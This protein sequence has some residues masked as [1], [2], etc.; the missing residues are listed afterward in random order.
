MFFNGTLYYGGEN[1]D[2]KAFSVSNATVSSVLFKS[3]TTFPF[4]GTIPSLSAN[5]TSNAILWT[6]NYNGGT[7]SIL[8]AYDPTKLGAVIWDSTMASGSRDALGNGIKFT[9]P[10]VADGHVFVGTASALV[11]YGLSSV[12]PLITSGAPPNGAAGTAYNF[13]YT[14]TG[15]PYPT[16][17]ATPGTLPPGLTLS[18]TGTLS[19]TP[20]SGGLFTGTV[21]ASNGVNPAVIQ[22]FTI[23]IT[24]TYGIWV[25][26]QG[27]TGNQALPTAI[28]SSRRRHQPDEIRARAQSVHRLQ[29]GQP[30]PAAGAGRKIRR[31]AVS[32]PHFHRRR[33]RCNLYRTGQQRSR[34]LDDHSVLQWRATAGHRDGAGQPGGVRL[35]DALHAPADLAVDA[36]HWTEKRTLL[37]SFVSGSRWKPCASITIYL[38]IKEGHPNGIRTRAT[39]VKGR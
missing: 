17:S 6:I 29:P 34:E 7:S 14:A 3:S 27:L 12:A 23:T 25:T 10:T 15:A 9:V 38:L 33:D 28:V 13:N 30:Q 37:H 18:T 19:G 8:R 26:Q 31:R 32:H 24:N 22:N 2:V 11:T 36:G 20:T 21:T 1:D 4:P 5:G 39:S 16:F 35:L